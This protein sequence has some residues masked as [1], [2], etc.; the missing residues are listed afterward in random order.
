MVVLEDTMAKG[1]R[2]RPRGILVAVAGTICAT[3]IWSCGGDEPVDMTAPLVEIGDWS[4]NTADLVAYRG[5]LPA[6]LQPQGSDEDMIRSLLASLIDQRIMVVEGEAL[7]Y[8]EDSEFVERQNRL[9]HKRL[10]EGLSQLIVGRKVQVTEAEVEEMYHTYNWDREILPA[11]ILS[12]TEADAL[13]VIRLLDQGGDFDQIARQRSIAADADRGGFLGQY[14]GPN[15]AAGELVDAAHGLPIGEYTRKPVRTQDG[16][17]VIKVVDATTVP[18]QDVV[19]QLTR[20]IYMGKFVTER[21]EFVAALQQ[22]YNVIFHTDGIDALVR[23]ATDASQAEG[24]AADLP[25]ITFADS[26]VLTVAD[27]SR[28]IVDNARL[29]QTSD[30]TAVIEILTGRVLADSLLLLES[31]SVGLD[32][33]AE[34]TE[35]RDNLYRRMIVTFLRKRKVLEQISIS[36][37]DVRKVYE[38]GKAGYKKPDQ[39][40]GSEIL[41]TTRAEAETIVAKLRQGADPTELV[42]TH[43]QRPGSARSEGHV[44][45][46]AGDAERWGEHFDTVWEVEPGDVVGPLEMADGFVVLHISAVEKDR[47]RS[48]DEMRLGLT[49]RLKMNRQYQAFEVYIDELR[50]QYEPQVRWQQD[51]VRRLAARPPWNITL[52]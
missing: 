9:L 22:K 36:P 4:A 43:S 10:V 12:A 8:H 47:L 19:Q 6:S 30:E 28:F 39:I 33:L 51:N 2:L 27:V 49:H 23:S 32:T 52:P 35:Y 5:K 38:E 3:L 42:V 26:H 1:F 15:D 46:G 14:F 45:I 48:F 44:H 13:E 24:D 21:R 25:A 17:E 37:E 31:R 50:Q 34:F 16:F 11:H 20:G 41:L 29:Q 40:N 7:G 18:L